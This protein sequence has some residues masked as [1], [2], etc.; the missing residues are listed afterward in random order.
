MRDENRKA[1][2]P[3]AVSD[4]ELLLYSILSGN[5]VATH[6]HPISALR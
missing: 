6:Q 5:W 1:R 4:I 2:N 3:H